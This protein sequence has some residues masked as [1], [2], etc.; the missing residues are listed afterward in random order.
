MFCRQTLTALVN[1]SLTSSVNLITQIRTTVDIKLHLLLSN[2]LVYGVMELNRGWLS[3]DSDVRLL[4]VSIY[5][6]K[7]WYRGIRK[8]HVVVPFVP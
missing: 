6:L 2:T 3:D 5:V 7:Y 4:S 8:V 1:L